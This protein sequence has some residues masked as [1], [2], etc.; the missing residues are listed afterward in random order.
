MFTLRFDGHDGRYVVYGCERYSVRYNEG[1][2]PE[3]TI[4]ATVVR[5]FR[6]IDDDNPYYEQIGDKE[7]YSVAYVTNAAGRT[8]DRIR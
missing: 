6:H 1:V 4:T 2:N 5:M 8:I 7:P 3:G